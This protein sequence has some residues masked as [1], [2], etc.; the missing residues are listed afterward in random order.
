MA[1]QE[2]KRII[3]LDFPEEVA[4]L[5]E[6]L[7]NIHNQ[8][9]KVEF[10]TVAPTELDAGTIS[11][12]DDGAGAESVQVK[13]AE[14]NIIDLSGSA[15]GGAAGGVLSGTYP[16]PDFAAGATNPIMDVAFNGAAKDQET[17]IIRAGQVSL[18]SGNAT[19][20]G[21]PFASASSYSV[22]VVR[23]NAAD[24]SQAFQINSQSAASFGIR[25]S[26]GS[27]HAANWIAMGT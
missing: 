15:C 24:V 5:Q 23:F 1:L 20:S 26:L 3:H 7:T 14:G 12:T 17:W 13:T 21:L 4:V 8:A 11:I 2:T 18:S 25:D 22:V 27:S 10:S 9:V 6:I 19:V 16:D